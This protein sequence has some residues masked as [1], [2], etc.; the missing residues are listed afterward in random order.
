MKW[1]QVWEAVNYTAAHSFLKRFSIF[2]ACY[3]AILSLSQLAQL[4]N[5]EGHLA[6]KE[7]HI[8][9]SAGGD[10]NRG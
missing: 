8:S 2:S 4:V 3:I 7:P 10:Q 1:I 6:A 9:P 5:I